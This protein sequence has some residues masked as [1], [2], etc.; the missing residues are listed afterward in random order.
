MIAVVTSRDGD[1]ALGGVDAIAECDGE[2]LV[3][4]VEGLA[5]AAAAIA[6]APLVESADVVVMPASSDGRSLAPR[7]A[8]SLGRPLIAGAVEIEPGRAVVARG[9]G[10]QLQEIEVDGP[11]VA[12]L[13]PGVRSVPADLHVPEPRP[14][15]T[16]GSS[17]DPILVEVTTPEPGRLDLADADRILA[18][19]AGLGEERFVDLAAEVAAALGMSL[20][21]T[22]VVTD[23]GWL[24]V[25]RQ[26]GTTGVMVEPDVY[27]AFGISGAV[28][29]T[30]GL[31]SP[32]RVVSV[33][34]DG[35][36]P[37]ATISDVN[38]VADARAVLT[39]L[40]ERLGVA[41]VE[42]PELIDG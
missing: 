8:A 19:G 37:L 41:A 11:Y 36:C 29:H 35:S 15:P 30:A 38:V 33:N 5:P 2:A 14:L 26:I 31:G 3:V 13:E 24:P 17:T 25:D 39:A 18:V 40:A 32:E 7:L 23:R 1:L 22:R 6:L 16:A 21:A 4:D 34:V 28:Q 9:G 27:V 42:S 12:T 20:G 10:T